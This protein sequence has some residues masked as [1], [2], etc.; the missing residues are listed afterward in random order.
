LQAA[1]AKAEAAA[2][3]AAASGT[4]LAE[5]AELL[6][7]ALAAA[8]RQLEMERA[9]ETLSRVAASATKLTD[10]P[11]VEAAIL[12]ARKVGAQDLDPEAYR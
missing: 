12:A 4:R 1:L 2:T 6:V 11:R 10:L 5:G 9:A 3:A 7:P 8:R